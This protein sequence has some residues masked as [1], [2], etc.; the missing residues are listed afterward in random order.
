M[1][2]VIERWLHLFAG[3]ALS[4]RYLRGDEL[5]EA[6]H[7]RLAE[8]VETW[9][10]RVMSVSWFMRC[11]N[12][13]IAR[14]ANEEDDCTGH[15]WEGRFKSQALLD[16]SAVLARLAYVGLNPVRAAIAETRLRSPT[17]P[18]SSGTFAPCKPLPSLRVIPRTPS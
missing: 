6:E 11:L 18:P 7:Q 9:R 10:K 13:R 2:E 4:Q 8:E 17:T 14:L 15:F 1:R 12:E 5:L 16:D 3:T